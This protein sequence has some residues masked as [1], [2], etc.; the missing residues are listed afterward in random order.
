MRKLIHRLIRQR[1]VRSTGAVSIHAAPGHAMVVF[2]AA[3]CVLG[4]ADSDVQAG[5]RLFLEDRAAFELFVGTERIITDSD[6]QFTDDPLTG[7]FDRVT[8]SGVVRGQS[9]QLD[10]YDVDFS[11]TPVGALVPG[12]VGGDIHDLDRLTVESPASQDGATGLGSWGIDSGSGSL[13][14]PNALLVDFQVTP[15]GQG[16]GFLGVDL[17]DFEAS[18]QYEPGSVLLYRQG[19]LVWQTPFHWSSDNGDGLVHFLGVAAETPQDQF[20]QI[21]IVLGDDDGRGS[22]SER[23]AADRL[24]FGLARTPEPSAML[25]WLVVATL[26]CVTRPWRIRG[27]KRPE[28]WDQHDGDQPENEAQGTTESEVI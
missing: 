8:R 28:N 17:I 21:A 14:T 13:S 23:W 4:T 18:Q 10:V 16:T 27:S 20:D 11:S 9:W 25:M 26:L 6:G 12:Q 2:L 1:S 3:L 5:W 24:S 7:T 22:G 19:S 15:Q